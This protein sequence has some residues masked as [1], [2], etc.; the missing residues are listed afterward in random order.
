MHVDAKVAAATAREFEGRTVDEAVERGLEDLGILREEAEIEV[1]DAGSRPVLSIFGG[2]PA[3]VRME[4]RRRTPAAAAQRIATRLLAL[5]GFPS[6][7]TVEAQGNHLDVA[8]GG[9]GA[10]GLL[11]GRKGETLLA[12]QHVVGRMV[13]RE[14]GGHE[15]VGIDVGGYRRRREEQLVRSALALAQKARD[16]GSEVFTEPLT[17][18]ERRLVHM[19]L[20]EAPGVRTHAIGE[21]LL[22]K[23]AITPARSKPAEAAC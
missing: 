11:I 7:V 3:R 8:V 10:D 15:Q 21:G 17:A 13:N 4:P 5:M 14:T 9:T 2:R 6:A 12:L 16:G 22:K 1:L 20:A 23:V 19:A 18:S